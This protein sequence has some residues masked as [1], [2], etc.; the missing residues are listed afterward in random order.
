M[1]VCCDRRYRG[2]SESGEGEQGTEVRGTG[3]RGERGLLVS[4]KQLE[5]LEWCW[6]LHGESKRK[7]QVLLLSTQFVFFKRAPKE[8]RKSNHFIFDRPAET[9]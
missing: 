5:N 9:I 7:V 4:S 8:S 6:C 1:Y 3:G 2:V